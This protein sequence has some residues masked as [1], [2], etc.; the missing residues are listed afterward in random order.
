M[1][2][3][4]SI[5]LSKLTDAVQAAVKSAAQKH[6]K[7]QMPVPNS[8]AVSYLIRGFPV[9]DAILNTVT[10]GEAQAFAN[11]VATQIN[12]TMPEAFGSAAAGAA[13]PATAIRPEGAVFSH[14]GH[15]ILGFPAIN[16]VLLER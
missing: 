10:V 11:E 9:P 12:A 1:A 5:S 4:T 16:E 2:R 8:L 14:G 15:L 3:A 13:A 6:P 7:F